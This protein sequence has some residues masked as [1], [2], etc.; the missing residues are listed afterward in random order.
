MVPGASGNS[1]ERRGR[2]FCSLGG[3]TQERMEVPE[4]SARAL[5]DASRPARVLGST[6]AFRA[7]RRLSR[8]GV[9]LGLDFESAAIIRRRNERAFALR[10]YGARHLERG[11]GWCAR[12][13]CRRIAKSHQMGAR[14]PGF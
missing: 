1:M 14:K 9:A 7:R 8:P 4:I 3:R 11:P 6:R 10:P 5:E 12:Y 2:G 13:A